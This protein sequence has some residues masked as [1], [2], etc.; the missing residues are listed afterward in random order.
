MTKLAKVILAVTCAGSLALSVVGAARP[1]HAQDAGET[2]DNAGS[3][4]AP[5][6]ESTEQS[7][8]AVKTH[9]L[10]IK[11]CWSGSVMDTADGAGT[12]TFQFRQSSNRKKILVGSVAHF[13]WPDTAKATVAMTGTI[14]SGGFTFKGNAGAN[15]PTVTGTATGD[16]TLLTGMVEFTG[17]CATF[18]QNVSFSITPGCQ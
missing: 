16:G 1:A 18:F 6:A 4:S 5:G 8:P 13:A 9:P 2:D 11:G 15:C 14:T 3:W 12:V 17:G 7:I 10:K